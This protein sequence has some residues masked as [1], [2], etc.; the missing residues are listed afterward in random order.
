MSGR[1]S[2]VNVW[3]LLRTNWEIDGFELFVHRLVL[4]LKMH[5]HLSSQEKKMY[6]YF[7]KNH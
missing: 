5:F 1:N 2:L 4:S 6:L 3:L 7:N